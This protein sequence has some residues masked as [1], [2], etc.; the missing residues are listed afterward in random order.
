MG[1][2]GQG[3]TLIVQLGTH[4]GY[5]YK[6][7][8]HIEPLGACI[9]RAPFQHPLDGGSLFQVPGFEGANASGMKTWLTRQ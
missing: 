5:Y 3:S 6:P 1:F 8:V 7:L 9:C 2:S 4:K